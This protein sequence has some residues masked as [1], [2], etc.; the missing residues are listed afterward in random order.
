MDKEESGVTVG[1]IF[2]TIGKRIWIALAAAVAV[3]LIAVLVFALAINPAKTTSSMSFRIQCPTS[4]SAKYPDGSPFSYRDL[5]RY[6]LLEEAKASNDAFS[7]LNVKSMLK[8]D[9][10]A[11]SVNDEGVYTLTV[12]NSRFNNT[13]TAERYIR[14]VADTLVG[15]IKENAKQLDFGIDQSTFDSAS[16]G[17]RLTFL[18]NQKQTITDRYNQWINLYTASYRV[19]GKTL[20]SYL[21]DA[22]VIY[23]E[24]TRTSFEKEVS[25]KGFDDL[26][27]NV[28]GAEYDSEEE[29]VKIAIQLLVEQLI[30]EK[31]FNDRIIEELRK[32]LAGGD[33]NEQ[34]RA[35]TQAENHIVALAEPVTD[36]S[37]DKN[38]SSDPNIIIMPGDL[39]LSEMLASYLKRNAEIEYQLEVL[40][41][42]DTQTGK[43]VPNTKPVLEFKEKVDRQYKSLSAAATTLTNVSAA[44]YNNDT[45]VSFESQTIN[46]S[47]DTSIVIVAVGV[48]VVAALVACVAAYFIGKKKSVPAAQSVGDR[49][50]RAQESKDDTKE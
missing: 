9:D 11:V 2:R 14:A 49:N 22:T 48:F 20:A 35:Q 37:A 38:T 30:E 36:P 31:S 44:I 50:D 42:T 46:V 34:V 10:I 33:P 40:Q 12:K 8:D 47:G 17:E 41:I 19:N 3:T 5:I 25:N 1:G 15:R 24:S 43:L 28:Y 39:G 7:S 45:F 4:D 18:K 32:D 26:D 27:L 21:A 23:G 29:Q 16:F 13:E 6:D